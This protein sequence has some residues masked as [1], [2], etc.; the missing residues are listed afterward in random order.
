MSYSHSHQ[1]GYRLFLNVLLNLLIFIV[2]L[3][4]G[5]ISNSLAL[6]TDAFHNLTDF[7]SATIS[8]TAHWLGK[9][10]PDS[11]RT[12]GYQRIEIF[13]AVFNVALLFAVA[14]V[15]FIKA[16]NRLHHPAKVGGSMLL[17]VSCFAM[18]INGVAAMLL[19]DPAAHN[20]NVRSALVHQLSDIFSSLGA[21]VAG[22]LIVWKGWNIADSLVSLLIAGFV[23]WGGWG[24]LREATNILMDAAP[25]WLNIGDVKARLEQLAEVD[26]V[27]HI[28]V[29]SLTSE[30]VAFAAHIMV[31]NQ[32]L[33]EVDRLAHKIRE[34]LLHEFQ[35]DHPTLQ[36]E[37][38]KYEAVALLCN[39]GQGDSAQPNQQE[40]PLPDSTRKS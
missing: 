2:E 40:L 3:I 7:S 37:T 32:T 29:W 31:K 33:E 18:V 28:H 21:V 5:V 27:H 25:S 19:K 6:I 35:I 23:V 34:I 4:T 15:I 16:Y 13:A 39:S 9:K 24:I 10:D 26:E 11:R 17:I 20:L 8:F 36:F 22:V 30:N 38:R 14:A 1:V 12:F